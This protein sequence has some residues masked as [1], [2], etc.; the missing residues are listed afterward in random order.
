M[1]LSLA[2]SE[3]KFNVIKITNIKNPEKITTIKKIGKGQTVDIEVDSDS[4][5]FYANNIVTSNSHSIAYAMNS[6]LSCYVKAHFPRAFFASWMEKAKN[7]DVI[8]ALLQNGKHQFLFAHSLGIFN[9]QASCHFKQ[10]GYVEDFE[11]S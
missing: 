5:V 4:H 7:H 6:Y 2:L 9:L 8:S 11:F 3:L 10:G 1:S